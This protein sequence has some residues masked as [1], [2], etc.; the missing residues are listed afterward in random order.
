MNARDRI[1]FKSA[2]FV[3]NNMAF[4][5]FLFCTLLLS[6]LKAGYSFCGWKFLQ[7]KLPQFYPPQFVVVAC[8]VDPSY[9]LR[10]T[11]KQTMDEASDSELQPIR[12]IL[13][14]DHVSLLHNSPA[15]DVS[16][17]STLKISNRRVLFADKV[18]LHKIEFNGGG[19]LTEENGN[20][21][22][23]SGPQPAKL[24]N[25]HSTHPP[26]G[27][28]EENEEHRVPELSSSPESGDD[29]QRGGSTEFSHDSLFEEEMEFTEPIG[30]VLRAHHIQVPGFDD[31]K[32]AQSIRTETIT[33]TVDGANSLLRTVHETVSVSYD[34]E[35]DDENSRPELVN[36]DLTGEL[37]PGHNLAED[38]P[39]S[40]ESQQNEVSM[41]VTGPVTESQGS[42]DGEVPMELTEQ[43]SVENHGNSVGTGEEQN[44]KDKANT[45]AIFGDQSNG[46]QEND[47]HD[48]DHH[49][50]DDEVDMEFTQPIGKTAS[51]SSQPE[52]E[53]HAS[54]S[55]NHPTQDTASA[56]P[57][58]P[59]E[60]VPETDAEVAPIQADELS[61]SQSTASIA[62][63]VVDDEEF[64][65]K[66]LSIIEE[67]DSLLELQ[68]L[69]PSKRQRVDSNDIE[70]APLADVSANSETE[71]EPVSLDDF[72]DEIGVKFYDDLE[73]ALGS[74]VAFRLPGD[75]AR[76]SDEDFYRANVHLPLLTV[77]ELC[78]KELEAKILQ[79]KTIFNELLEQ[80]RLV[81][82]DVFRQ[83]YSASVYDR[84]AMKQ[85]FYTLKEYTAQQAAQVWYRWR[86]QLLSNLVTMLQ[87]HSAQ[88][89]ADHEAIQGEL[90]TAEAKT[91]DLRKQ[92]LQIVDQISRI[93]RIQSGL[94]QMDSA[95]IASFKLR[96]AELNKDLLLHQKNIATKTKQ[97]EEIETL[98]KNKDSAIADLL[99]QRDQIQD[100]VTRHKHLDRREIVDLQTKASL[101][102]ACAGLKHVGR[103]ANV[104][105]FLFSP[106]L[107]VH[108][109]FANPSLTLA[110]SFSVEPEDGG[111][112][113]PSSNILAIHSQKLAEQT[114]F[115]NIYESLVAFRRKWTA[116]QAIDRDIAREGLR[117]PVEFLSGKDS[118]A[119]EFALQLFDFTNQSR[120]RVHVTIAL[121]NLA[122]Y[123]SS[124]EILLDEKVDGTVAKL[125]QNASTP[126]GLRIAHVAGG[127]R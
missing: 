97:L 70:Y 82:P 103:D 95:Q 47:A 51:D 74:D 66:E 120:A 77:Y 8:F 61:D 94:L 107:A 85:Y 5:Y 79:G 24:V 92:H 127:G 110:I 13:K 93:R 4:S 1:D 28:L 76:A 59:S 81:N 30:N 12:S 126:L 63:A 106:V 16:A 72:L 65:P 98:L 96:L 45:P 10:T 40:A 100:E 102:Q 87:D 41:E 114:G 42:A 17:E 48:N 32:Y 90:E 35:E 44:A 104:H 29:E 88:L 84:M 22:N 89:E 105:K 7:L 18:K 55:T 80:T 37:K 118:A 50:N 67:E 14:R 58:S 69:P 25:G 39:F 116:L 83:Y 101:Y 115:T 15:P 34:L 23:R 2:I 99:L 52:S 111:A 123:P 6:D 26:S 121:A 122:R 27:N 112:E 33:Q 9:I 19:K 21:D 56:S 124:A 43:I 117:H 62:E 54:S 71:T 73:I 3:A 109:D 75:P 38:G 125:M 49:D 36:M 11:R 31:A 108:V 119:V 68:S 78:S 53:P 86:I 57:S 46:N 64:A 20:S 113:T 60:A 91:K